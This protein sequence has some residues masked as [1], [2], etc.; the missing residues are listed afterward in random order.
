MSGGLRKTFG[1]FVTAFEHPVKGTNTIVMIN[2][3][4]EAKSVS[5]QGAGLPLVFTIYLTTSGNENCKESGTINPGQDNR[6]ELP[7][8]SVVTLQAGGNPL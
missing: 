4:S 6:F 2:A 8:K 1:I 5:V 7:A 3:G